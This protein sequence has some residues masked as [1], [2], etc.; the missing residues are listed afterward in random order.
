[1]NNI[2]Y[3]KITVV[4]PSYN[5]GAYLERTI[6]SV[7]EQNY[8]NL[9][10]IIIDGGSTDNSV[11]IIKKYEKYLTYWVSEKDNGQYHAL[12]KGFEKSTGEV[13]GWI[14]SDDKLHYQS[15]FMIGQIFRDFLKVCWLQGSPNAID[16]ND[17]IVYTRNGK[18]TTKTFFYRKKHIQRGM[19]IQQESTYWRRSL[20]EEAG[21]HISQEYKYAG[22]FEL[23]IRFF[24]HQKLYNCDA[25]LGTFRFRQEGQ[26]STKN[27]DTYVKETL[28]ILK[29]Y[30]LAKKEY[31]K[32]ANM[33][34]Y[35]KCQAVVNKFLYTI[36]RR[37][38][39]DDNS[40]INDKIYFDVQ[41][42]TF[43]SRIH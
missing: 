36:F 16:E 23:W 15:L 40:V 9:E 14:N 22:D 28:D 3:P 29:Q 37:F 13:M 17:K 43:C 30:P 2:N 41:L 1:M 19:Y 11:E 12:Q 33:Q 27:Y 32:M 10:Y 6:L 31:I 5:Q 8:P 42:Q 18:E 38:I 35:E 26:A 4:T 25:M 34:F 20:W 24:Q 39:P 21:S 7:I